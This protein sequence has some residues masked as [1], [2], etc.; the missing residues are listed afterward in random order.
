MASKAKSYLD[1][2]ALQ[3]I[4]TALVDEASAAAQTESVPVVEA[5]KQKNVQLQEEST[6]DNGVRFIVPMLPV[7]VEARSKRFNALMQPS[8]YNSLLEIAK[9]HGISVNELMHR[10]LQKYVN[11]YK[12]LE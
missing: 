3:F 11:D 9:A 1:N 4:S 12:M 10:V 5:R 6:Q 7:H 2:P 8:L